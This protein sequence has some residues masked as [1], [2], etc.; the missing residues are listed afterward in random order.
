[1]D[2]FAPVRQDLQASSS[3]SQGSGAPGSLSWADRT[4]AA[5]SV[6][7]DALTA[8]VASVP[9]SIN[10]DLL[11]A[12][13]AQMDALSSDSSLRGMYYLALML[14]KQVGDGAVTEM[15]GAVGTAL[16]M[17][18]PSD[19]ST[20]DAPVAE[21]PQALDAA[22]STRVLAALDQQLE[23][24]AAA[25][26]ARGTDAATLVESLSN[27]RADVSTTLSALQTAQAPQSLRASASELAGALLVRR[28]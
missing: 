4:N 25:S 19:P 14:T 22:T 28:V 3:V 2:R 7:R 21:A 18:L 17:R 23:K 11:G 1:M 12:V 6:S 24:G 16:G 27:L 26:A 9:A 10:E 15:V 13:S 8:S 20:S 5:F